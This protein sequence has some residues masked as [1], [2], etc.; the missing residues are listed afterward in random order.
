MFEE[1]W[2]ILVIELKKNPRWEALMIQWGEMMNLDM[3]EEAY[4][5]L[6]DE[7]Y[8]ILQKIG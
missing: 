5:V 8:Y 7:T 2:E 6:M 3:Y 1:T 4:N